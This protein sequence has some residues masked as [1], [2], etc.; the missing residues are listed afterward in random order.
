MIQLHYPDGE[1]RDIPAEKLSQEDQ[2][3]AAN[4]Q[5]LLD[6]DAEPAEENPF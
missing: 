4:A 1:T 3:D 5:K 2:E 6:E